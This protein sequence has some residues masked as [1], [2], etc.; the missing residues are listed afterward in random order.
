MKKLFTFLLLLSIIFLSLSSNAQT[1]C[2]P[3]TITNVEREGSGNHL[4]WTMP[5]GEEETLISQGE[6]LYDCCGVAVDLGVYHRFTPEE[7]FDVNGGILTQ[8]VFIPGYDKAFQTEPGHTYT[9]HIYQGG[10]WGIVGERNPGKLISS[11]ELNN[12]NLLF[13]EEN[14]I[15]LEIPVT[16]NASQELWIGFYCTNIDTI[17]SEYKGA[18]GVD[19]GPCK[20]GLGNVIFYQ[21]Q[22]RTLYEATASSWD[23]NWCIKGVVQT[24]EGVSVNIYFNDD[25]I[26]NNISGNTYFHDNPTGE[27][28]CYKVEVNCVVGG[29]SLLSN[30]FCIP[31]VGIKDNEQNAKFTIYPNPARTELRV[32]SYELRVKNIEI[33]DVFGRKLL[34]ENRESKIGESEIEINISHLATGIYFIKITDNYGFSV[35]RFVKQ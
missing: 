23:N 12:N 28:H 26:A 18:A 10:I 2:N 25:N 22:W 7:L 31:G 34:L 35:Q 6:S 15:T 8:V 30:E 29:T 27:E 9:L 16:I 33:Y 4:T 13:H 14:T 17:Q 19:A 21:N 20:D 11:L 32:T 5:I 1:D 24:K 3:A